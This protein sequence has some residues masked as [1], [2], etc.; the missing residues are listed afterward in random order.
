MYLVA[1]TCIHILILP[2]HLPYLCNTF[3]I[4]TKG[5]N[6]K[7]YAACIYTFLI[8]INRCPVQSA[9]IVE[10]YICGWRYPQCIFSFM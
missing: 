10:M 4:N 1:V 9:R 8:Y 5:Q 3:G 7:R 6:H 2:V